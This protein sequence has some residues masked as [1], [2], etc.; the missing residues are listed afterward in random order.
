MPSNNRPWYKRLRHSLEIARR[1]SFKQDAT[2]NVQTEVCAPHHTYAH[3]Q[4]CEA[5]DDEIQDLRKDE[6]N[7]YPNETKEIAQCQPT[8]V[9]DQNKTS[10]TFPATKAMATDVIIEDSTEKDGANDIKPSTNNLDANTEAK[11]KQDEAKAQDNDVSQE[12]EREGHEDR[13]KEGNDIISSIEENA[14]RLADNGD[15]IYS[16][17]IL[18]ND[19]FNTIRTEYNSPPEVARTDEDTETEP[20]TVSSSNKEQASTTWSRLMSCFGFSEGNGNENEESIDD[21]ALSHFVIHNVKKDLGDGKSNQGDKEEDG[22]NA[23]LSKINDLEKIIH[24]LEKKKS[25]M[26]IKAIVSESRHLDL[27]DDEMDS[28]AMDM[29]LNGFEDIPGTDTE[30]SDDLFHRL[31]P[32]VFNCNIGG[33]ESTSFSPNSSLISEDSESVGNEEVPFHDRRRYE[34]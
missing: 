3:F 4:T 21:D 31:I 34:I 26:Q 32:P 9:L 7:R 19:T 13:A 28:V 23:L 8:D 15:M 22:K 29:A 6:V 30:E 11:N 10:V 12:N 17:S 16:E 5:R 2:N 20:Q 25:K 24:V 1:R 27:A 14:T 33:E 18:S